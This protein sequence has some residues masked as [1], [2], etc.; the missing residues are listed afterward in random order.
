[1][2]DCCANPACTTEFRFLN[3]GDLYALEREFENTHF[4]WVC[5]ACCRFLI[6]RLGR[7]CGVFAEPRS[8]SGTSGF[9]YP[10]REEACLKLVYRQP[11][12]LCTGESKGPALVQTGKSKSRYPVPIHADGAEN[13]CSPG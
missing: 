2:I 3:G 9:S 12:L 4:F 6:L 8:G 1:M 11:R 10:P 13:T 7:D 5:P